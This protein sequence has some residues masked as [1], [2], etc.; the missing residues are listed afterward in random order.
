MKLLSF[1]KF[2]LFNKI[3]MEP[4]YHDGALQ[5]FLVLVQMIAECLWPGYPFCKLA[6]LLESP[7]PSAGMLYCTCYNIHIC[8]HLLYNYKYVPQV[9]IER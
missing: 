9:I 2:Y 8:S 1:I 6:Y 4:V 3:A 5:S 7:H